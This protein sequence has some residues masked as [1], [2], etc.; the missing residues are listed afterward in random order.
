MTGLPPVLTFVGALDQ[1]R[2]E[3]IS[4]VQKLACCGVPVEF[5]L[6]PGCYHGFEVWAPEAGVSRRARRRVHEFLQRAFSHS[7]EQS[8]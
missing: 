5:T 8:H 7:A 1:F 3:T 2:D 4:L 6:Y